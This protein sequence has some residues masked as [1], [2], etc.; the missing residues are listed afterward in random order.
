METLVSASARARQIDAAK[1]SQS[2]GSPLTD[3]G[4]W[5][6]T[7]AVN[8]ERGAWATALRLVS[9]VPGVWL[10]AE[11]P[12]LAELR[13]HPLIR[14][15]VVAELAGLVVPHELAIKMGSGCSEHQPLRERRG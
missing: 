13:L 5:V 11:L 4:V 8:R 9:K 1:G 7:G 10:Q 2:E 14:F 15:L 6:A 12:S 3:R